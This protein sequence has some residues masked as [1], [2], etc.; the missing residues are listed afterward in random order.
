MLKSWKSPEGASHKTGDVLVIGSDITSENATKL[1]SARY[2]QS[3]ADPS[4]TKTEPEP[5]K[6]AEAAPAEAETE[7]PAEVKPV[8]EPA[9]PA[10]TAT[11]QP[12]ESTPADSPETAETNGERTWDEAADQACRDRG[13]DPDELSERMKKRMLARGDV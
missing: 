4:E 13:I 5:G 12:V 11:A 10:E 8:A 2:A 3:T 9:K 6:P 1:I 7:K